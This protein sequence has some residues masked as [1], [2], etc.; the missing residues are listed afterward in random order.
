MGQPPRKITILNPNATQRMTHEMVSAAQ[1]A[2]G[3]LALVDGLT[4]IDGPASIQGPQDGEDCLPG[5]FALFEQAQS[6]GA[7][8]V[9]IGCFDD[10]GLTT[11]RRRN[12]LPVIGM[13]E[14]GCI[15]AS[16]ASPAFSVV[17]TLEV[18]VPVIADNIRRIGLW[19][20]CIGVHASGV[21]VLELND[22]PDSTKRLQHT[23]NKA[24]EADQDQS[25]V[26]GCSGM[27]LIAPDISTRGN[28]CIIDPV[29]AALHMCLAVVSV[30]AR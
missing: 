12:S 22:G 15:A 13:G 17:T 6:Q 25:I 9:I 2:T 29:L 27:S 11:L 10:T 23:I 30:K 14:A 16:L 28:G 1:S 8:A 7:D 4:N 26:L 18:S 19:D 21:P 20:R 3:H 5:L 24:L